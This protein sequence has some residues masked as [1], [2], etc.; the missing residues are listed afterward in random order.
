MVCLAVSCFV[1]CQPAP[2][3]T[4]A[5]TEPVLPE[6]VDY[7]EQVKLDMTSNTAKLEVTVKLFVDGDT[8]HF[9]VPTDISADGVLKARYIAYRCQT[10]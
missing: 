9:Y 10:S 2:D 6:F 1:G 7:V 3:T 4:A 5:P 8:T